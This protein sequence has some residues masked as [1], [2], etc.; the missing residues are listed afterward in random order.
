[1]VNIYTENS[2]TGEHKS[3]AI[4]AKAFFTEASCIEIAPGRRIV[5]LCRLT[6]HR[7]DRHLTLM[8]FAG[9]LHIFPAYPVGQLF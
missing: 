3:N 8:I 4:Q 7:V 9:A 1:M 6:V 2:I 5:T